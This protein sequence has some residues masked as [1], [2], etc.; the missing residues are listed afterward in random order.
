[1]CIL[2]IFCDNVDVYW[3]EPAEH[4]IQQ[5]FVSLSV[6][7]TES[8]GANASLSKLFTG[9]SVVGTSVVGGVTEFEEMIL[10]LLCSRREG[11]ERGHSSSC[12][13]GDFLK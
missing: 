6:D 12:R 1:V 10:T 13:A 4:V 5:S 7:M 11:L 3:A 9:G 8:S 2:L